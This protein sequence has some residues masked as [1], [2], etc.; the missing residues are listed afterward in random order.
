[1]SYAPVSL[2]A[3]L[4]TAL[5]QRSNK[6]KSLIITIE[7]KADNGDFGVSVALADDVKKVMNTVY[8][9]TIIGDYRT[10]LTIVNDIAKKV[11]KELI[12]MAILHNRLINHGE[13]GNLD[14][15]S[16]DVRRY[17]AAI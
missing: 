9:Y 2:L 6:A 11:K 10:T 7:E 1:M 12:E 5:R 14:A 13:F 16:A 3:R 17:I 8:L 4:S 15:L